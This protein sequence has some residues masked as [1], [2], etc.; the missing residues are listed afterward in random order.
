[1]VAEVL[2][3]PAVQKLASTLLGKLVQHKD[4][5]LKAIQG[6][7]AVATTIEGVVGTGETVASASTTGV[8]D[9]GAAKSVLDTKA[10]FSGHLGDLATLLS[11]L[12]GE[13]S[14]PHA[15]Q[16]KQ[17]VQ[18]F[19]TG[20]GAVDPKHGIE[21]LDLLGQIATPTSTT[22]EHKPGTAERTDS[23]LLDKEDQ[24]PAINSDG[25]EPF[26]I[27]R[28]N[29]V[30]IFR[31]E[32]MNKGTL[33]GLAAQLAQSAGFGDITKDLPGFIDKYILT[34][35]F[36]DALKASILG[37]EVKTEGFHPVQEKAFKVASWGMWAIDKMPTWSIQYFPMVTT[38]IKF[39]MPIWSHIPKL[40]KLLGTFY[41]FI[42]EI[43]Q[44][45]GKFQDETAAIKTAIGQMRQE[46]QPAEKPVL[47]PAVT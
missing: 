30:K 12:S 17:L 3:N 16:L 7:G 20:N 21:L 10:L 15:A 38:V 47:Q 18:I 5:L 11:S 40:N 27:V 42:D 4:A 46:A 1:M 8:A 24:R 43:A 34:K 26:A 2:G 35:P 41:P 36:Q 6:A 19:Q 14:S 31:R 29:L 22:E 25:G 23:P 32:L 37:Q 28:D 13:A 39:S 33:P 45:V 9:G 44:F